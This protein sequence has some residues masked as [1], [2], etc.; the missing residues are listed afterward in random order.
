MSFCI[1]QSFELEDFRLF[2]RVEGGLFAHFRFP[3]SHGFFRGDD[4]HFGALKFGKT[5]AAAEAL[6][7]QTTDGHLV[8]MVVGGS[9]EGSRGAAERYTCVVAF[10][11]VYFENFLFVKLL[12]HGAEGISVEK[13][14]IKRNRTVIKL[15][16]R[17]GCVWGGNPE[18][19]P[20]WFFE[21]HTR[22]AKKRVRFGAL[23]DLFGDVRSGV[24]FGDE[25]DFDRDR[26]YV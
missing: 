4:F 23:A 13:R 18:G 17:V 8:A 11:R 20:F 12:P 7:V 3:V 15:V 14:G 2:E 5:H 9:E 24:G 21:E 1:L 6:F 16:E 25:L 22:R 19:M 26:E 10:W